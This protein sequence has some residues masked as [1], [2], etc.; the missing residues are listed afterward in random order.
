MIKRTLSLLCVF[1]LIC[2]LYSHNAYA[3]EYAKYELW[4]QSPSITSGITDD[5]LRIY[6]AM[7]KNTFTL[8][9]LPQ[10]GSN[11][12]LGICEAKM[13]DG[14]WNGNSDTSYL[15]YYTLLMTGDSFI[16]LSKA[17]ASNEYYWSRGHSFTD[18]SG[19]INAS[20]YTSL[21][22]EIP[23]YILNPS[24]KYSNYNMTEYDDYFV[25]TKNARI[26][27]VT[28]YVD[29][30]CEGY[31]FVY[32]GVLYRGQ[33]RYYSSSRYYY[34]YLSDGSTQ[35]TQYKAYHFS[36]GST[37][38]GTTT[39]VAKTSV[40]S[41]NGYT[42]YQEGFSSNVATPV[43]YKIPN[44]ENL[45]FNVYQPYTYDGAAGRSYYYQQVNVYRCVDGK[46]NLYKTNTFPTTYTYTQTLT[47][48]SLGEVDVSFYT[49]K[50]Y[51]PPQVI[52]GKNY[53]ILQDGTIGQISLDTTT[54]TYWDFAGYNNRLAVIRNRNG[55]S[56]LRWADENGTNQYWQNLNYIFFNASGVMVTDVDISLKV[57]S[58]GNQGQNGFYYSYSTFNAPSFSS[59]SAASVKS[60]WG[61][62]KS[63]VFPDGRRVTASW[64]GMGGGLYELW[65]NIVN[66]DGTLCATGPTGYSG[67]FGST[68]STLPLIA[69]AVNNSKFIVSINEIDRDWSKEYYRVAVVQETITGEVQ[70]GGAIGSKNIIPPDSTDTEPVQ[71]TIDFAENDLPLGYNIK[72]NV[73]DSGKLDSALRQQVNV[74]RLN[75]VVI[76][77]KSGYISGSQNTG[78]AL[79]SYNSYDYSF[80][81]TYIRFYSSG[82]YLYWYCYYPEQLSVGIYNKSFVIGDKTVYVTVKIIAVPTNSGSSAVV[83]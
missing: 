80:G 76:L 36:N 3:D 70:T 30:G 59:V 74:I 35:A 15:H 63:N 18:I 47:Q 32:G 49:S 29:A 79:S 81:G 34:Y 43:Y 60:W 12:Y 16:I 71:S 37:A 53:V 33:E 50:G 8:Y 73:I 64:T 72:N 31:P 7:D 39:N 28:E 68:F 24:G 82:Q 83:F 62:S 25:I 9:P 19:Q 21:G 67:S 75:D 48:L 57:V 65:Y 4:V 10:V 51:S 44:T 77:K 58:G 27:T 14:G 45:Y 40:T 55:S 2:G 52:I 54:Y 1:T 61:R 22:Y 13:T 23:A 42:L 69:F 38:Y 56:Y 66:P 46:M 41:A 17:S 26:Y 78:T 20:Y 11:Y 6:K 5:E